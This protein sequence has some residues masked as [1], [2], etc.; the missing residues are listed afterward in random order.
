M[1]G[2]G[3]KWGASNEG[4]LASKAAIKHLAELIGFCFKLLKGPHILYDFGFHFLKTMSGYLI[5]KHHKIQ[6]D[7]TCR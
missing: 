6:I 1:L 4:E 2:R 7:P 3:S 5:F